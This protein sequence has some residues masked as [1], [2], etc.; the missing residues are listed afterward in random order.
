M[1]FREALAYG[2][3]VLSE[4][5]GKTDARILLKHC[6]GNMTDVQFLLSMDGAAADDIFCEYDKLLRRRAAREPL[7]YI[8]GSVPFLSCEITADERALIPRPE[9]E[10]MAEI[11][12][13]ELKNRAAAGDRRCMILD[14]CTGSGAIAAA[15]K[16]ALPS[17][18]VHACDISVGALSLAKRNAARNYC[19]IDFFHGDLFSAVRDNIYDVIITNPPYISSSELDGLQEEVKREPILALDGGEDGLDLIRRIAGEASTRLTNDGIIYVE[20]GFDQSDKAKEL[21]G[22]HFRDVRIINDLA[23]IP[24]IVAARKPRS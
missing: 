3:S 18:V 8:I 1:T 16:K 6:A 9:T 15:I 24:R 21:F 13:R 20:I 12:V 19:E 4:I 17:A 5:D 7:Q 10:Y 22:R 23:G 11:C 2:A 14:L